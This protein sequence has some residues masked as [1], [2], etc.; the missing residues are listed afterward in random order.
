MVPAAATS[1][2]IEDE[3]KRYT[4][5]LR[6][7]ARWS[8]G[9]AVKAVDFVEGFRRAVDPRTVSGAA[10]LLRAI[11]NAPAVLA[12]GMPPERLG[13]RAIDDNTLEIRLSHA[14]PYFPDILTNP[15]ASPV[16]SSSLIPGGGF[17]KPGR[18]VSNGPY[19]LAAI[20]PGASLLLTRNPNY[21]D[22][23]SVAYGQ[24]RYEFVADENAEFARFRAGELDVTNNVPEQ[25]FEELLAKPG[26]G[27]Q[28]RA[29]L[30]TFYLTMNTS[31]GP[32]RG[33]RGLRE[34]LSLA[35]DRETIASAVTRSGQ[36]PAYSLVPDD[37][38]NYEPAAYAWRL[39]SRAE[40]IA[41]AR[42][43]YAAAGYSAARPLRLR[44]LYNQNELIEKV[45]IAIAA[46]WKE[47]L[48]VES[49]LIQMEFKAYLAS[50]ADP[51]QWDV[52][53]VGWTADYNDASSFLDTM[54]RDSPQNFG[55]WES[56]P[57]AR[58]LE[59]AAGESNPERRR[60]T[61]QQAESLMLDDYP[62]LPVYFY[63]TRRLV[64]PRVA[65]PA[66][67][68]MFRT[69]SKDFRPA[70]DVRATSRPSPGKPDP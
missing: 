34:A 49:E 21:W 23:A 63:V 32:L 16:H 28:H 18:T 1:W 38:W 29:M 44:L 3:G 7:G 24:V 57:Y 64:Q 62:L 22:Q 8:N 31:K 15:V 17:S 47:N 12:G 14:V 4:F 9:D 60:D 54:T 46:M 37:A 19:M 58:L 20:S 65:A 11:E 61:L 27:L 55:R 66:I 51:A 56:A 26:S 2:R 10:D 30:A 53:R 69:Y 6:P 13:V 41:R 36:V 25:R 5:Q 43:L 39:D 45:C 59:S 42:K 67:N 70:G 50:R 52:V 35:V 68:P 33:Q 48:G 40:R